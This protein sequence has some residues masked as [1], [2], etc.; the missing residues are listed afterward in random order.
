MTTSSGV[1]Y[2]LYDTVSFPA[3]PEA[4]AAAQ[5]LPGSNPGYTINNLF[6]SAILVEG[7]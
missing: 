5:T 4:G 7:G 3:I 1:S 2:H 6:V